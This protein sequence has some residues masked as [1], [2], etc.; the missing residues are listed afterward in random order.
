MATVTRLGIALLVCGSAAADSGPLRLEWKDNLLT[1]HGEDLPGGTLEI[2]YLE[3][4]CRK[5]STRRKWEE[6]LIPHETRLVRRSKD[7]T[8]IQLESLVEPGVRVSH[9]IK[10][11]K[12]EVEFLLT[13][14]NTTPRAVDIDWAQPCVRVAP[15]TG[16]GQDDYIKACFIVT[17]AGPVRLDQ[18]R[19]AKE[20]LYRGGQVYVPKG[21]DRNDVNPRP[22][23]PDV[24]VKNLMG[25]VSGDGGRVL[26]MAWDQTQELFQGVI[27]CI[28]A[29]FRVGGLGPRESKKVRGKLYLLPNDFGALLKRYERDFGK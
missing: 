4:F 3:A 17:E 6:T 29:D 12:D 11:R 19:R 14:H 10:A 20:A 24:P 21:I 22:I 8:R 26:A 28:H 16:L 13:I 9:V 27:T 23:S 2:W 18:T 7:G 15:F 5:G 25:C 1:V